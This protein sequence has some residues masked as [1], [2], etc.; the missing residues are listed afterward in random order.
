[1]VVSEAFYGLSCPSVVIGHP[2]N[3]NVDGFPLRTCGDDKAKRIKPKGSSQYFG[4]FPV[5]IWNFIHLEFF[6]LEFGISLIWNFSCWNLEFL[7]FG[8][9]FS[10]QF[11][12]Q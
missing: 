2:L 6:L 3:L 10:G 11:V 1:M 5:G 12:H 9:S 8:I 4:I 7:L